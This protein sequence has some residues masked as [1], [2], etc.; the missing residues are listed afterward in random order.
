MQSQTARLSWR[1]L[2]LLTVLEQPKA[3]LMKA[4]GC[5]QTV[6]KAVVSL[7]ALVTFSVFSLWALRQYSCFHQLLYGICYKICYSY[8]YLVVGVF[9]I[10]KRHLK[11]LGQVISEITFSI[12]IFVPCKLNIIRGSHCTTNS[13]FFQYYCLKFILQISSCFFWFIWRK[14]FSD[15]NLWKHIFF[16]L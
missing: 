7:T 6:E 4:L 15:E 3:F 13:I 1:W 5:S 14:K 16:C 9:V 10:A 2:Y 11:H 8:S 12:S